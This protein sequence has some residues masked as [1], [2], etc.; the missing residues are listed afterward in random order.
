M[1][2]LT[3]EK[4]R[5]PL[6]IL[7]V[8]QQMHETSQAYLESA[9]QTWQ[10]TID[11]LTKLMNEDLAVLDALKDLAETQDLLD[12][13]MEDAKSAGVK[14]WSESLTHG[15][16]EWEQDGWEIRVRETRT[17]EVVHAHDFLDHLDRLGVDDVVKGIKVT[18]HRKATTELN[19]RIP[20]TGLE[21]QERVSC[22]IRQSEMC[23][24]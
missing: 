13:A 5:D 23:S 1:N 24:S 14:A 21:I 19:D 10:P 22:A 6:S 4:M 3:V 11:A 2:H 20:L 12:H 16:K 15:K 7:T 17:P 8:A 18:L 9:K